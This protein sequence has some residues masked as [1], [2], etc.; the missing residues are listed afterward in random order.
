[1]LLLLPAFRAAFER[2]VDDDFE[3]VGEGPVA[4]IVAEAGDHDAEDV[5]VGDLQLGLA[6]RDLLRH[7]TGEVTN[8][9]GVLEAGVSC[10]R[11]QVSGRPELLEVAKA[12][13]FRGVDDAANEGREHD[14]IVNAVH[15]QLS[16][17]N[18]KLAADKSWNRLTTTEV[19]VVINIIAV[20][21]IIIIANI[22]TS[23]VILSV[24]VVV[25]V[26]VR[27][28]LTK[29]LR[30]RNDLADF[31]VGICQDATRAHL[32]VDACLRR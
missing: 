7:Q 9:N 23:G 27:I 21:T 20:V 30:R 25:S 19:A 1:M 17:A 14:V 31:F 18:D 12:L 26:V 5:E 4:E 3:Q 10:S 6:A 32:I 24:V 13:E 29:N 8:A 11:V 15:H 22:N 28:V 2:F 16:A